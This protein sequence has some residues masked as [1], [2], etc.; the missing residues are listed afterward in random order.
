MALAVFLGGVVF[1]LG[2][3]GAFFTGDFFAATGFLLVVG[4]AAGL[5][6]G[7]LVTFLATDFLAVMALV[8]TFL[9]AG[10]VVV[11]TLAAGLF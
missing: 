6:V 9:T 5:A 4:L 7:F 3:A 8:A 11:F 2:L 1:A 10:L